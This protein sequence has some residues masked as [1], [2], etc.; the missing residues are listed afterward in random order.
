GCSSSEREG[1]PN[2]STGPSAAVTNAYSS[3]VGF[4]TRG[5]FSIVYGTSGVPALRWMGC[6]PVA[7]TSTTV[8]I[9]PA[10]R[11]AR[12]SAELVGEGRALPLVDL[13]Q[14]VQ[15]CTGREPRILR[16]PPGADRIH[17]RAVEAEPLAQRIRSAD[18][19]VAGHDD[20]HPV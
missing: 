16:L 12:G 19:P 20:A 8:T 2:G 18:R 15:G 14:P 9:P 1:R 6:S 3:R 13:G 10:V 11:P 5:S 4:D 7:M 17:V